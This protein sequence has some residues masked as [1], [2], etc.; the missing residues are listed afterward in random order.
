MV[1]GANYSSREIP[2]PVPR[3]CEG[4]GSEILPGPIRRD[5]EKIFESG[6]T[7]SCRSGPERRRRAPCRG[8][9]I[10][11]GVGGWWRRFGRRLE[12]SF[13]PLSPRCF[14]LHDSLHFPEF[15]HSVF[16]PR[17]GEKFYERKARACS[18]PELFRSDGSCRG[19]HWEKLRFS[20][21]LIF[22]RSELPRK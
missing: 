16:S 6:E 1:A 8:T 7:N 19:F 14:S 22:G 5:E 10:V 15:Q 12:T 4:T 20:Q 13:F 18:R 2:R 3:P 9:G 21:L 17:A 11:G